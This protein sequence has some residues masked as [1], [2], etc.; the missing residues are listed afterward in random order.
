MT[1][2]EHSGFAL[3]M[4]KWMNEYLRVFSLGLYNGADLPVK[5]TPLQMNTG[6]TGKISLNVIYQ[7]VA[8]NIGSPG[9]RLTQVITLIFLLPAD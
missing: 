4:N 2:L 1:Y 5:R 3:W 7:N 9:R 8:Q 6:E